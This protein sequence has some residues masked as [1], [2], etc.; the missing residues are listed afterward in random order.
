MQILV[1]AANCQK[2]RNLE[3]P[4][5][6]PTPFQRPDNACKCTNLYIFAKYEVSSLNLAC[7][8]VKSVG[9]R[10]LDTGSCPTFDCEKTHN[11][12]LVNKS[13]TDWMPFYPQVKRSQP[14]GNVKTCPGIPF[15]VTYSPVGT[16]QFWRGSLQ[17]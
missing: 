8:N 15:W 2:I 1:A 6:N 14:C 7:K 13:M 5:T 3:V 9:L 4:N 12:S 16:T 10:N 11:L 17:S